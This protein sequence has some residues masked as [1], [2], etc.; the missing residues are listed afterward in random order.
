MSVLCRDCRFCLD[1]TR[2]TQRRCLHPH[3]RMLRQT[4]VAPLL[5]WRT[6]TERNAD[7]QC[8][9]F[10]PWRWWEWLVMLD[11]ASLVVGRLLLALLL[12]VWWFY[13]NGGLYEPIRAF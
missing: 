8:R 13:A 6:P 3:A 10:R 12:G 7:H 4:A 5:Q 2:P 9:D 1:A 11:P